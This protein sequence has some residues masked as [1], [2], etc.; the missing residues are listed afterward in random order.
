MGEDLGLG[1]NESLNLILKM[2]RSKRVYSLRK[3]ICTSATI[4]LLVYLFQ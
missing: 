1:G 2:H 3:I 4:V